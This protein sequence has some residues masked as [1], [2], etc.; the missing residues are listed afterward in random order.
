MQE[1]LALIQ[2]Q[3]ADAQSAGEDV[4][5]AVGE[6]TQNSIKDQQSGVEQAGGEMASAGAKAAEEKK[7]EY[8]KAEKISDELVGSTPNFVEGFYHGIQIAM[9][10]NKYDK[11]A[12]YAEKLKECKRSGMTTVTEEEVNKLIQEVKNHNENTIG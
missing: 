11:A 5:T 2:Q 3:A 10:L 6:G 9:K 8:E 12:E 1:L 4:G 7:G